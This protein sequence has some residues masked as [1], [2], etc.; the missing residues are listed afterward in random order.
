MVNKF[1][2]ALPEAQPDAVTTELNTSWS[3]TSVTSRESLVSPAITTPFCF[4]TKDGFGPPLFTIDE[5]VT[6]P[7]LQMVGVTVEI[8]IVGAPLEETDIVIGFEF[9]G[10]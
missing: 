2:L 10:E 5:K 3:F 8:E 7:P 6:T 1:E 9:A 4:Q